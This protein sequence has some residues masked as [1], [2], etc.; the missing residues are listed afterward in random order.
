MIYTGLRQTPEQI[1]TAALQEDRVYRTLDTFGGA[2]GDLA[3]SN[4]VAERKRMTDVQVV[5]GGIIPDEDVGVLE[6][7]GVARIFRPGSSLESIVTSCARIGQYDRSG[8][9]FAR[10][11]VRKLAPSYFWSPNPRYHRGMFASPRALEALSPLIRAG[12][13]VLLS[14]SSLAAQTLDLSTEQLVFQLEVGQPAPPPQT[15]DI[16]STP[17]GESFSA[18][19]DVTIISADWLSLCRTNGTSPGTVP[20]LLIAQDS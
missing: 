3:A 20:S 8:K 9:V 1:V 7:L 18:S 17:S 14:V 19:I 11:Y 2:H 6:D 12:A 15:F 13:F 5:V 10:R 4:G 16:M